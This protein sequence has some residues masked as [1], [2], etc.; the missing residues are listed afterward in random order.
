MNKK[1]ALALLLLTLV[2]VVLLSCACTGGPNNPPVNANVEVVAKQSGVSL[3]ND[4]VVGF[5]Y[6]TLFS[7]T[8]DGTPIDVTKEMLNLSAVSADAD[9]FVVTCTYGKKSAQVTISVTKDVW[10][11]ELSEQEITLTSKEAKYYNFGALF[12]VKRNGVNVGVKSGMV[13]TNLSET[14][15]TY[16]YKVTAGGVS[17]TL[18]VV[19]RGVE[20]KVELA[21]S[22]VTVRVDAVETFDFNALFTITEEGAVKTITQDMVQTDVVAQ[23][24]TYHYT[25]TFGNDQKTLVVHVSDAYDV[26][27]VPS[28]NTLSLSPSE[29]ESLDVTMLFSV[30][31]D[32][33]A[34]QVTESMIDFSQLANA[35]VGDVCTV[36]LTYNVGVTTKTC[37]LQ[38]AIVEEA[39]VKVTTS[40]VVTYPNS[41]Y[42]D[43]TSLFTIT[44]GNKTV[45]VTNEMISGT[46]NY[47][48]QDEAQQ[49]TLTYQGKTYV[50][51]VTVRRGVI[52]DFAKSSVITVKVGTDMDSYLFAEDFVVLV[53]GVRFRNVMQFVN[54]SGVNNNGEKLSDA[55]DFSTVGTY[56]AILQIPYNNAKPSGLTG[57]K[58]QIFEKEITYNVVSV[59]YTLSVAEEVVSLPTGTMSFD[60]FSNLSLVRNGYNT[61]I[62]EN[63]DWINVI[64]C[65]AQVV[66]EPLDFSKTGLQLVEIDVFV[67]CTKVGTPL[68]E[69]VRVSYYVEV[70]G[71]VVVTATDK[72]TFGSDT[73]YTTDLFTIT[74]G[75]VEI[76][77]T[78]DMV[79][80]KVDTFRAGMYYVTAEYKGVTATAKVVVV[81]PNMA[82]VY[83][84]G[85]TPIPTS[86][87]DYDDSGDE[88][89]WGEDDW[90]SDWEGYSLYS[91]PKN[92]IGEMV[93][94]K[95][96][97]I[98]V[99][100]VV[101]EFVGAV[102]ENTLI[103]NLGRNEHT[104]HYD[105]GVVVLDPDNSIKMTFHD[106]KRPLVYFNENAW[107]ID[108]VVTINYGSQ[109]VLT[110]TTTCYSFDVFH[111]V[112]AD[113]ATQMWY[114]LRVELVSRMSSDTI[115]NVSWGECAFGENFQA[116]QGNVS[117][118][119]FDGIT[120]KFEMQTDDVGKVDKTGEAKVWAGKVFNGVVDGKSAQL[121]FNQTEGFDYYV[122][123]QKVITVN[124]FDFNN[125]K[126]GGVDHASGTV[127]AYFLNDDERGTCSY[128]FAVDE[129]DNSFELVQQ[130]G[131]FGL[132]LADNMYLFLDGYGTGIANF[133]TKSYYVSQ[134]QYTKINDEVKITFFNVLPNFEYGKFVAFS[135]ADLK[136]VLTVKYGENDALQGKVF[137]NSTITDGALVSFSQS[138]FVASGTTKDEIYQSIRIVTKDGELTTEQKKA[139]LNGIP[140]VDLSCVSTK[141]DGFY[142][143]AVTVSVDGAPKTSYFA[144]Q[145]AKTAVDDSLF[146]EADL[147]GLH[148]LFGT[149]QTQN[150]LTLDKYGNATAIFG[151]VTYNG[152]CVS[153][154]QKGKFVVKAFAQNG[155]SVVVSG[156]LLQ[157]GVFEV[158][159]NG[160]YNLVD[161]FAKGTRNVAGCT[162]TVL[163]EIKVGDLST[164]VL[165]FSDTSLGELVSVQIDDKD[166][167]LFTIT[168]QNGEIIVAKVS[169]TGDAKKGIVLADSVRGTYTQEGEATLVLDG[170]G[171]A[172]LDGVLGTYVASG[173]SVSVQT[174]NNVF[175]FKVNKTT[176]TYETL[177]IN[178][179]AVILGKTYTANYVF[180]AEDGVYFA[181]TSFTFG[182]NGKVTIASTS[183][184]YVDDFG[185]YQPAFVG[186]G[187]YT[188]SSNKIKVEIDGKTF[189][190][191]VSDVI[192]CIIIKCDSTTLQEGDQ[193]YFA[194]GTQ[195]AAE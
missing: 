134:F 21:Q 180:A 147:Q 2:A 64:T 41:E 186:E 145:V 32:G 49:I 34:V 87:D 173:N 150:V 15:G 154:V 138:V 42:I 158:R 128:K 58:M 143:I 189:A 84:T 56:K 176:G 96:G 110:T 20:Y 79:R 29:V 135:L 169:W 151:G 193:G 4:V 187:T 25:V 117:T 171:N 163:R 142:Q 35:T 86:D 7:V 126:N 89:Y 109:H 43:L 185:K 162:D 70:V 104:L 144:V 36:K 152:Y 12:S 65:Y 93:I 57:P 16:Y 82:G 102:D 51:T 90:G 153:N 105:N 165:A 59:D 22:E 177:Q 167:T 60:V 38:V 46:I 181:T 182:A 101:A 160:S 98:T 179:G 191:S 37:S 195:F 148:T 114:C 61:K 94:T 6:T 115:Y 166:Q 31:V 80:G 44:I 8:V 121:V 116:V 50:S 95:D 159:C 120:V 141:K 40:N 106:E 88:G 54:L 74:D 136:N 139:T 170:F 172:K 76:P 188:V 157:N 194:A 5:D 155:A 9:T 118:L 39:E 97:K 132:Y 184:D 140:V 100:G 127:L 18:T 23:V 123:G 85:Q 168:K 92:A 111:V 48:L 53:N 30:Y 131:I 103:I 91:L 14:P 11:V 137:T 55:V 83:K 52:I 62:V 175:A 3:K 73:I 125:M 113:G 174:A 75:G 63:P 107:T 28:Y 77:V 45:P 81:N 156:T 146:G 192:Q 26:Y 108:Q 161:Y 72:C 71:E 69:P 10:T 129:Q 112:S 130:D 149:L 67:Y 27:V 78:T 190:F 133:N 17:Q 33:V 68:G 66:S 1:S 99:H 183:D 19:V 47:S 24:G 124:S 164:Y 13:E 178:V 119:T 122:D